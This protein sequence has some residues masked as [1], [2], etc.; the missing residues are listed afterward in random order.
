MFRAHSV[1]IP[2]YS[3]HKYLP[4]YFKKCTPRDLQNASPNIAD[5][6]I[7]KNLFQILWNMH[8]S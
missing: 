7:P 6:I 8:A 3:L 4:T 2:P 1:H 5:P